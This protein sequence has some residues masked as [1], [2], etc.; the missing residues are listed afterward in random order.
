M[1]TDVSAPHLPGSSLAVLMF[2]LLS[3]PF[4]WAFDLQISYSLVKWVCASGNWFVLVASSV[5]ALAVV[6][7]GATAAWRRSTGLGDQLDPDGAAGADAGRFLAITAVG[8]N[9]LFAVLILT[10]I[11][12]RFVLSPC[13]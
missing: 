6:A 11:V 5:G 7:L 13:E 8:L 9:I 2:G 1:K 12:P 10:S 4:A 3:G